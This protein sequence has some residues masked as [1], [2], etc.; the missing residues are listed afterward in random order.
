MKKNSEIGI[1]PVIPTDRDASQKSDDRIR[2]RRP[3]NQLHALILIGMGIFGFY[4]FWFLYYSLEFY[5]A[6][7]SSALIC[8]VLQIVGMVKLYM[9]ARSANG[10]KWLIGILVGCTGLWA[11]FFVYYTMLMARHFMII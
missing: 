2:I 7:C 9:G 1:Q 11:W 3:S 6:A 4:I 5:I 8:T 10:A